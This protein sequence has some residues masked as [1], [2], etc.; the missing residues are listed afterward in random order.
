MVRQWTKTE[1]DAYRKELHQ[2]Y[3]IENKSLR[4]VATVLG[5]ADQTVFKRL[6]RLD[7]P[8][9]RA[10]KSGYNNLR[11]DISLPKK[12]SP[13][14]AESFG[15]LLGDGH[16]SHFQVVVTLG[17]GERQYARYVQ[18][19]LHSVF[20]AE[21]RIS[22]RSTGHFDIYLGSTS[23]TKWLT[24]GGLVAHKVHSQVDMP[25]WILV[26]QM[27]MQA[28]LRGFFDTDGSVY[29][30]KYGCQISLTNKSAPLLLSLQK[31]LKTLGYTP[32]AVSADRVYLTKRED[33]ER[34]FR[35]IKPAN[36][37][38]LRR[39]EKIRVG[40]QVVKGGAL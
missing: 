9:V 5:I 24:K 10:R 37:K 7:I 34:F 6:Q 19:L 30:L 40:S 1:E 3:T 29:K 16:I 21:P 26:K 36:V 39:F 14:L 31:M 15:V 2:L 32:S 12:L 4:E 35:E 22:V 8:I 23:L 17:S 13:E 38:H 27:Y 25:R 18:E 28:F 20:G 11:L 33:V